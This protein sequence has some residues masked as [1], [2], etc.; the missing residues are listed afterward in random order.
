MKL[1]ADAMSQ[2]VIRT[3]GVVTRGKVEG[4]V[5]PTPLHERRGVYEGETG[6]SR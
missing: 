5:D 3:S 2:Y 1:F 4:D 6:D